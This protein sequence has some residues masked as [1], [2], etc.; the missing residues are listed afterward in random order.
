MP[1][2]ITDDQDVIEILEEYF[3]L[4]TNAPPNLE[5]WY[6]IQ[7]KPFKC[8]NCGKLITYASCGPHLI[9]VFPDKDADELAE[10]VDYLR[11]DPD[12]EPYVIRYSKLY[13]PCIPYEQA[14]RKGM[15]GELE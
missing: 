12:Y 7:I 3:G 6:C 4:R 2:I 8:H 1:T 11:T 9:L 5:D 10:V 13:G 14:V 15:I